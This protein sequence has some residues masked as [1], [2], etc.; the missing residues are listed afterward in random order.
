MDLGISG[1]TLEGLCSPFG[2]R[3]C[4]L[5]EVY[6]EK[7]TRNFSG[8]LFMMQHMVKQRGKVYGRSTGNKKFKS[9]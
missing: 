5:I 4:V 8:L 2:G 6:S 7:L 1:I 9:S 3:V